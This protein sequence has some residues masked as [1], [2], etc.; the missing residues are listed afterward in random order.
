MNALAEHDPGSIGGVRGSEV[1]VRQVGQLASRRSGSVTRVDV[2]RPRGAVGGEGEASRRWVPGRPEADVAAEREGREVGTG[3]VHGVEP[4][5]SAGPERAVEGDRPVGRIGHRLRPIG[6]GAVLDQQV[7]VLAASVDD[8]EVPV[9]ALTS[10]SAPVDDLPAG[11]RESRLPHRL[12]A[13]YHRANRGAL[14]AHHLQSEMPSLDLRRI[15]DEVS[16]RRPGWLEAV[17]QEGTRPT[18]DAD[19]VDAALLLVL[20]DD[21]PVRPG[22]AGARGGGEGGEGKCQRE[23]REQDAFAGGRPT[24]IPGYVPCRQQ[25]DLSVARVL[26]DPAG[27]NLPRVGGLEVKAVVLDPR[28]VLVLGGCRQ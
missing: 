23:S 28:W 13:R 16:P 19:R 15:D 3:R 2:R 6:T 22:E 14:S 4:R 24:E 8:V 20:K 7:V 10:T 12:T 9:F 26:T 21:A 5:R 18:A 1:V 27:A 25:L 17:G 11:G